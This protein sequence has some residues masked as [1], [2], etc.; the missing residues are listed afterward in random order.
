MSDNELVL[1]ES[2]DLVSLLDE[3]SI[4]V[5]RWEDIITPQTISYPLANISSLGQ[6]CSGLAPIIER[7]GQ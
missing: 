1:R 7:I 2:Q 3:K 4:A 5:K 6:V